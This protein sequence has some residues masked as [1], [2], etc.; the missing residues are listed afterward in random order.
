MQEF[1]GLKYL[2]MRLLRTSLSWICKGVVHEYWEIPMG[3]KSGEIH[4]AILTDNGKGGDRG[5]K[6]ERYRDLLLKGLEE[7]SDPFLRM[8]YTFYLANSYFD[9]DD[10]NAAIETYQ[11][12]LAMG[13]WVEERWYC[14]YRMAICYENMGDI[15]A[16]IAMYLEAHEID[17]HRAEHLYRLS[18]LYR[19]LEKFTLAL[20]FAT[21]GK[22]V[23]Y[24][25]RSLFLEHNVY[26]HLLDFEISIS[27]YY[28]AREI[29]KQS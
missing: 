5:N 7:E 12:R 4:D 18:L 1:V 9:L 25:T 10:Y 6:I 28:A 26:D 14:C 21:M 3:A 20:T 13:G 24:P 17:P 8:R 27:G 16:S 19:R 23:G 15:P 29:G 22:N 2:N 11:K